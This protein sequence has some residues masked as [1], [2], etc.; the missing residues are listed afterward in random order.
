MQK[1]VSTQTLWEHRKF[2]G[3]PR[4]LQ[5]SIKTR[6][7]LLESP[8]WL[9]NGHPSTNSSICVFATMRTELRNRYGKRISLG[10]RQ[11][12]VVYVRDRKAGG[13]IR[14]LTVIA[15]GELPVWREI[16]QVLS[17]SSSATPEKQCYLQPSPSS[18]PRPTRIAPTLS[19][20]RAS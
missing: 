11:P 12:I 7:Q 9:T 1:G 19:Q 6:A 10:K 15:R 4:G 17:V 16:R 20:W 5:P 3:Q 18:F 14:A 13:S 8:L 2:S